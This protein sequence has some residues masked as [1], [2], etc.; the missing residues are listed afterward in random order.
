MFNL[1]ANFST[2][3]IFLTLRQGELLSPRNANL[4]LTSSNP[5]IYSTG[6]NDIAGGLGVLTRHSVKSLYEIPITLNLN[7]NVDIYSSFDDGSNVTYTFALSSSTSGIIPKTETIRNS[8]A[9]SVGDF[10]NVNVNFPSYD[11]SPDETLTISAK[12][13]TLSSGIGSGSISA[14]ILTNQQYNFINYYGTTGLSVITSSYNNE[15]YN[16]KYKI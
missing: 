11:L 9:G 12:A 6:Y 13:S 5:Y 4:N 14:S 3:S 2:S 16:E 7:L 15:F 8:G 10:I 1:L